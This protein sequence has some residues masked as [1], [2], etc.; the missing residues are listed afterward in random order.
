[1]GMK[2]SM[3]SMIRT[4]LGL[5]I[6]I[7][8]LLAV[9]CAAQKPASET[10]EPEVQV[11]PAEQPSAP[12]P[13]P[14]PSAPAE[15]TYEPAPLQPVAPT[16]VTAKTTQRPASEFVV[17]RD[18]LMTGRDRTRVPVGD[19][20]KGRIQKITNLRKDSVRGKVK[21]LAS[22]KIYVFESPDTS[23]HKDALVTFLID[24]EANAVNVKL[25]EADRG[26]EEPQLSERKT[27]VLTPEHGYN[28]LLVRVDGVTVRP[29]GLT[30]SVQFVYATHVTAIEGVF[31]SFDFVTPIRYNEEELIY[32]KL[33]KED[34][35]VESILK[36]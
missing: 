26:N 21:D 7:M 5:L 30:H 25:F 14:A 18:E 16:Q 17:K 3:D 20:R 28:I 10:S 29:G 27:G 34:K 24:S 23:L 2:N 22:T 6:G 35:V 9:G 11:Q 4:V 8:M 32:V 15:A 19:M 31:K 13:A 1:M 12:A 33:D 36:E